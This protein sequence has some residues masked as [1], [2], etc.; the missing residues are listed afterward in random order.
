VEAQDATRRR[1][2]LA[3]ILLLHEKGVTPGVEHI[4]LASA[5][6]RAGFTSGA[7]Y[8]CWPTQKD[9]HQEL[10]AAAVLSRSRH[11]AADTAASIRPL[12]QARAPLREM[13]RIGAQA[14]VERARDDPEFFVAL[15][16]RAASLQNPQ[17][18]RAGGQRVRSGLSA[19][20][21]FFATVLS[22]SGRRCREPFTLEHLTAA[23][24]ALSEGFAIQN[25]DQQWH[26]RVRNPGL[27]EGVGEEWT[28]LGLTLLILLEA[29]TEMATDGSAHDPQRRGNSSAENLVGA[30]AV[31]DEVAE[32]G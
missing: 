3:G 22:G 19:H 8:R 18:A 17:L 21:E 4:S 2:L 13:I 1:I 14:N 30:Q 10:A 25:C 32:P 15:A 23:A 26:P 9:F 11:S 7:G 5:C 28:L 16:L 31:A 29:M 12:L 24:A 27:G 20:A 6:G